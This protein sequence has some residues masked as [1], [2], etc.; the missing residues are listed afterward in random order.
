MK[1]PVTSVSTHP[2]YRQV[3]WSFGKKW[4]QRHGE[5]SLMTTWE[6]SQLEK[7]PRRGKASRELLPNIYFQMLTCC[8]KSCVQFSGLSRILRITVP[9]TLIYPNT[10]IF[11]MTALPIPDPC[12]SVCDNETGFSPKSVQFI[13]VPGYCLLMLICTLCKN[14]TNRDE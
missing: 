11:L 3:T 12:F 14:G 13:D 4:I 2:P 6:I 7:N 10:R 5:L 8:K 9:V 1:Q